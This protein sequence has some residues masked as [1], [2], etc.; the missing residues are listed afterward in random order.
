MTIASAN[1]PSIKGSGFNSYV[2]AA[3]E[4]IGP[5]A[6]A[7]VTAALLPETAALL[8]HPPLAVSQ[9][10]I[11]TYVDFTEALLLHGLKN[12]ER[13]LRRVGRI[14]LRNDLNGIYR[15]FIRMASPDYIITRAAQV[16]S[17]YWRNNGRIRTEKP[18]AKAVH[19]F[20]EDVPQ[21]KS[22]FW[23]LQSG[24]IQSALETCGA[25]QVSV[26]IERSTGTGA[27]MLAQWK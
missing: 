18:S 24:A 6:L 22:Y 5:S 15:L 9:I 8:Q 4:S 11:A 21:I 23:E 25:E 14:Q 26:E 12:N 7:A 27:L 16:Y 20:Y 3:S 17:T 10:P 2:L 13:E 1:G 19:V